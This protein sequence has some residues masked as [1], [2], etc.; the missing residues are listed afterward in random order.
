MLSLVGLLHEAD[1]PTAAK[2]IRYEVPVEDVAF[3]ASLSG[4][5]SEIFEPSLMRLPEVR[6][7]QPKARV[8]MD[9]KRENDTEFDLFS[10]GAVLASLDVVELY[11]PMP[12]ISDRFARAMGGPGRLSQIGWR[13]GAALGVGITKALTNSDGGAGPH[14]FR[15]SRLEFATIF[16]LGDR[17]RRSFRP[18]IY[19]LIP[20]PE[21]GSK[22]GSRGDFKQ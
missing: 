14:L 22:P 10:N 1:Y 19:G 13:V 7:F 16:Q 15:R 3:H 12:L 8:F 2:V 11:M 20:V 17:L 5:D 9:L 4:L 18:A 21:S 6:F